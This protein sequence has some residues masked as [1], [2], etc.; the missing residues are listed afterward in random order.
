[1]QRHSM[2]AAGL[3]TTPAPP[4]PC[5]QHEANMQRAPG[6]I[7]N[8]GAP[9]EAQYP[10]CSMHPTCHLPCLQHAAKGQEHASSMLA[11]LG[12]LHRETSADLVAGPPESRNELRPQGS[13]IL[14]AESDPPGA[15]LPN[16][17]CHAAT[18]KTGL[19]LRSMCRHSGATGRNRVVC[20]V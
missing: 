13:N 16:Q 4:L 19:C 3:L 12:G 18:A 9:Q 11:D 8:T 17:V 20:A 5:L 14:M 6:S 1:M 7:L 2:H 15:T 10:V